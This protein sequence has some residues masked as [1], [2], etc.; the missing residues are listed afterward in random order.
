MPHPPACFKQT[1]VLTYF[2]KRSK[3]GEYIDNYIVTY[4]YTTSV[5]Q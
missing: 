5:L 3:D 1:V 2:S 4:D